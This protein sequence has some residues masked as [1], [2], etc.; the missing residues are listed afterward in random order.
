MCGAVSRVRLHLHRMDRLTVINDALIATGNNPLNVEFDGSEEWIAADSSYRRAV[1]YLLSRHT[2]SFATTTVRLAGRLPLSP[3][4]FLDNAYELPSDCLHVETAFLGR[5]GLTEY[6]IVDNK[7][8]CRFDQDVSVKYVRRAPPGQWPPR[9]AELV[10]MKVEEL[11]FR[12][13]NESLDAATARSREV[14]AV[15]RELTSMTDQQEPA[16]AVFRSRSAQRRLGGA[17]RT[18]FSGPPYNGVP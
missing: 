14:E 3:H 17:R 7:L 18:T 1:G 2:W 15:L 9:F 6:E 12:G 8:C 13:L 11:L 10:T 4:P 16:R 5:R